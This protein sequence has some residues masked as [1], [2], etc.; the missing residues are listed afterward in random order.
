MAAPAA[1]ALPV[2]GVYV[3]GAA[4]LAGAAWL[5]SPPGRH[6]SETLGEAIYEG[7]AN[8]VQNIK[9]IFTS[10]EEEAQTTTNTTTRGCDGPHGGRLQVQG[11][12]PRTDP[13]SLELSWPWNRECTPPL[14]PE[15]LGAVSGLL[16]QTQAISY[17]SVGRRG[18]AFSAMSKHISKAPSLGFESGHRIGFGV[19]PDGDL[20]INQK[21]GRNAPR[22]DLEVHR[23][24]AFGDS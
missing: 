5:L 19:T 2:A 15:G 21:A 7:G 17:R 14:R 6:A 10:E 9:D 22:V 20:R 12:A 3:A 16:V 4:L 11:Y 18:K 1:P 8:A 13:Y 24:R 23:G